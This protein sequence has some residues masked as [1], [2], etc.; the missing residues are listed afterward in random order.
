[1][2]MANF[3][4]FWSN[5]GN[6]SCTVNRGNFGR[7]SG[8]NHFFG[9]LDDRLGLDFFLSVRMASEEQTHKFLCKTDLHAKR[10]LGNKTVRSY[11]VTW[12]N[13]G[14]LMKLNKGYEKKIEN[15]VSA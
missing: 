13:F 5:L 9:P 6:L 14:H 11:P 12:G 1:M 4:R 8:S 15:S 7:I 10:K 3:G 2:K